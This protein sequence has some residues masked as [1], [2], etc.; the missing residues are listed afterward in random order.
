MAWASPSFCFMP[1]GIV[2]HLGFVIRVKAHLAHGFSN[3]LFSDFAA[4]IRQEFQILKATVDADKSWRID[5]HSHICRKIPPI[6]TDLFSP[7]KNAAFV[8]FF[9][10]AQDLK[11]HRFSA[12]VCTDEAYRLSAVCTQ[13]HIFKNGPVVKTFDTFLLRYMNT[14]FYP[15]NSKLFASQ[16]KHSDQKQRG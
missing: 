2:I 7:H 16:G 10:A 1:R 14:Y 8:W 3:F 13:R 5:E 15:P 4:D 11:L 12:A 6:C 9:K